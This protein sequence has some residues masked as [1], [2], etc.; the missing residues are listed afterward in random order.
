MGLE[1]EWI[2]GQTPL[3]EEEKEGLLIPSIA[4]HGEL[5][6]FEQRNIEKA[7]QWTLTRTFRPNELLTEKFVKRVHKKMYGTVWAWAGEFRKTNKNIG[8]DWPAIPVQLRMLLG[9]CR[10]WIDQDTYPPDEL[11]VRFKHRMVSI[12]CF[13]NGNGRHS[14]LMADL[15]LEHIFRQP[16]FTWGAKTNLAK[17]GAMRKEYLIAVKAADAGDIGPLLRFARS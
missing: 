1:F 2:D 4:T 8:I 14:R 7:I 15:L 16:G 11:A 9:D 3:E 13:A 6:E 12:H 17:A 10:Y 5:D